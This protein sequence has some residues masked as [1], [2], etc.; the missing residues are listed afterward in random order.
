MATI[1]SAVPIQGK[2]TTTNNWKMPRTTCE[3]LGFWKEALNESNVMQQRRCD[4]ARIDRPF[5]KQR[6]EQKKER[7]RTKP[8]S[9]KVL[10]D[11]DK[12]WTQGFACAAFL[13]GENDGQDVAQRICREGGFDKQDLIDAE[14]EQS[15]IDA[16]FG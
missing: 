13:A 6:L 4:V 15:D 2:P 12:H 5:E 14:C 8:E 11:R 16:I 1:V 3:K 9:A 7:S 10:T